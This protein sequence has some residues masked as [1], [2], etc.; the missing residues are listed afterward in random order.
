[1]GPPK[2]LSV[3][4]LLQEME[5]NQIE[6]KST[7]RKPLDP[8][9]PEKVINEGIIKTVAAF[10]N[11]KGGTL[12][13][14]ISDDGDLLGIQPDLDFKKQ[15]IDGY[16]NWL[17]TMLMGAV[18]QSN[19]A[20]LVKI[21]FEANDGKDICLVDVKPASKPVYAKTAKGNDTFFVRIGNSSRV[22]TG[23]EMVDYI[24][25]RHTN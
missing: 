10:M 5:T 7:A 25:Q 9:I 14:G 21:R 16:E 15:D 11:A 20:S 22:L 2:E 12:G 13:I 3:A 17:S 23:P 8:N 1:M 6:F 19:V 18:G 4:D 24:A